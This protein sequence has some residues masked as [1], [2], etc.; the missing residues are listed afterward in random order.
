MST[1]LYALLFNTITFASDVL[2]TRDF[3]MLYQYPS[4]VVGHQKL[5]CS[6]GFTEPKQA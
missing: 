2:N 5:G 3:L 1:E 4:V 6:S